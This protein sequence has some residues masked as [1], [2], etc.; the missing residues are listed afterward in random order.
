MLGYSSEE[1]QDL[2][3]QDVLVGQPDLSVTLLDV[4]GHQRNAERENVLIHRRDGT[5]F[6][7]H[8][9]AV[10]LSDKYE[11]QVLLL[12]QDRSEQ[13]AIEDRT[14]TLT[15]RALLGEVTAIFAHEVRNPINNISTGLQVISS[16]LGEDH[17][18][19]ASLERIRNE[20]T[21][22]DRL[23]EDVLFFARP[24]ELKMEP[25]DLEELVSRIL[26]RWTPRFEQ[27]AIKYHTSFSPDTPLAS[28]DSRTLEQVI[29]KIIT[30]AV[31]AMVDGGTLSINLS[32][33][34]TEHGNAIGIRIADTGP[35]IPQDQID[36]IFDPF[37]TTK[38]DGTGLGLA[39][40]RRIMMAHQGGIQIESYPGAGS[41]FILTI[42][43]APDD[44]ITEEE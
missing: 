29:T 37:F 11:G 28:G 20:C 1:L 30:N 31:Q 26:T 12:L 23:M 17:P 4:V 14:E 15:Q 39:I 44:K 27:S 40:S 13:K 43:I 36:R 16:R 8:L 6:P 10:S 35:G 24:L 33:E 25:L 3:I 32:P 5:P 42:P 34:M 19:H 38:K 9:K 2:H 22:L 18:Q 21:R 7:I 41:V